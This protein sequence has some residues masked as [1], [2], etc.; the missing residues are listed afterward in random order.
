[1]SD[2]ASEDTEYKLQT[3]SFSFLDDGNFLFFVEFCKQQVILIF[4]FFK[5]MFDMDINEEEPSF[6][7]ESM[8]W[9]ER[10]YEYG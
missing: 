5:K 10:G 9:K 3:F 1:M 6:T 2:W 4:Y 7:L 8:L